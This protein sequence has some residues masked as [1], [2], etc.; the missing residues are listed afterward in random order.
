MAKATAAEEPTAPPVR[1]PVKT[2]RFELPRE[3]SP[4]F[5]VTMEEQ[6]HV[7][8]L[9]E[10]ASVPALIA[11]FNV[12]DVKSISFPFQR[13]NKRGGEIWRLRID[14]AAVHV[15]EGKALSLHRW[16]YVQDLPERT[17]G[18]Q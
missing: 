4:D 9:V 18:I 5:G 11:A 14:P 1:V 12:P 17:A 13:L 3:L 15:V 6:Y 10:S 16:L 8:G 7:E 2:K